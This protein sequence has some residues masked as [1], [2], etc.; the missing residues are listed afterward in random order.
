MMD[1]LLLRPVPVHD[2]CSLY[3]VF[4]HNTN[5]MK[6][7]SFSLRE[8]EG[9]TAGNQVFAQVIADLQVRARFQNQRWADTSFPGITFRRSAAALLW[10]DP[11]YPRTNR[12]RLRL[13]TLFEA[14]AVSSN[15]GFVESEARFRVVPVDEFADR[16]I[17]RSLR[18]VRLFRTADF[19]CSR[20]GSFKTAFGLR[21]RLF[22]AI[23]AVCAAK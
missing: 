8:Y 5:R 12:R 22:L 23:P 16:V 11:F 21:L 4:G 2:P 14:D 9:V 7:G 6:F 18:E 15:D 1:T 19:D 3:Q 20:S 17:I 13:I 10:A